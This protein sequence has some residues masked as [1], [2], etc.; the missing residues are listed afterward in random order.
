MW[1]FTEMVFFSSS[2]RSASKR[3]RSYLL[4]LCGRKRREERTDSSF[5]GGGIFALQMALGL[6]NTECQLDGFFGRFSLSH[7][8]D[9]SVIVRG[10]PSIRGCPQLPL[11]DVLAI[12]TGATLIYE[13]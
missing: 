4:H 13:A 2:C 12:A 11:G 6:L 7:L 1:A 9:D 5:S 3:V 10:L 8:V